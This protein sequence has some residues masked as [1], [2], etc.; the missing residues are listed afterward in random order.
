MFYFKVGSLSGTVSKASLYMGL[1]IGFLFGEWSYLLT[2]LLLLNG[3][4]MLAG[5]LA[6]GRR[7]DLNSSKMLAGVKKKLGSWLSLILANV[8]DTIL[9]NGQ[10]VALTGLAF[11]L[12][13]NEGLSIVENIGILGVPLP[14]FITEYLEQIR[15]MEDKT[16]IASGDVPDPKIE[17]VLVKTEEGNVQELN[18]DD[19]DPCED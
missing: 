19:K 10:P 4:D 7:H 2:A 9:F 11:V 3:V 13:A 1:S 17:K 6:A 15:N 16:E 18:R 12:I 8:I 14:D 5:L